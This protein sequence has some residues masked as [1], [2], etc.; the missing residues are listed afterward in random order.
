[1]TLILAKEDKIAIKQI[2]ELMETYCKKCLLK[3][4]YRETMGKHKAHQYCISEC[5]IGIRIKQIGNQLQ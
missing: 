5:S 3:T 1:M 2:D 4:H